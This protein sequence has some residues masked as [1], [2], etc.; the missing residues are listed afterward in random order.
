MSV[1][2]LHFVKKVPKCYCT[3]SVTVLPM[4]RRLIVI[5][6]DRYALACAK[7]AMGGCCDGELCCTR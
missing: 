4:D 3:A 2:I 5:N 6:P 1:S 7:V